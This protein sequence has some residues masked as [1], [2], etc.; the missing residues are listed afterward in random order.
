MGDLS[1]V[2]KELAIGFVVA[3]FV[4]VHVPTSWWNHIFIHGHGAWT[5]LENVIVAPLVSVAGVCVLGR[6]RAT[7]RPPSGDTAWPSAA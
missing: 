1:M 4:S 5:V 6:Q 7:R 3:G 2:R